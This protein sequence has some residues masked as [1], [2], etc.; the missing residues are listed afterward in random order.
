VEG[1]YDHLFPVEQSQEPLLALLGSPANQKRQVLFD[2]GHGPLARG[3]V[4]HETLAWLD[5]FLGP[6]N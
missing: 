2:A 5:R 3:Q 6:P 4:I 1:R